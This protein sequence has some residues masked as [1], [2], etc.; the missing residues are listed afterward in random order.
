MMRDYI[1]LRRG[2]HDP[3][4]AGILACMS[5]CKGANIELEHCG[6]VPVARY[7]GKDARAPRD[8][9]RVLSIRKLL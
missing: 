2:V 5:A 9:V 1:D 6:S 3:G 7:A 4:S 8:V